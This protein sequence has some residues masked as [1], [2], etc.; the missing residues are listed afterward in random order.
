MDKPHSE[1]SFILGE[2]RVTNGSDMM[3]P[4]MSPGWSY[5][6]TPELQPGLSFSEMIF[7]LGKGY[8]LPMHISM[9]FFMKV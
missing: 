7:M 1:G 8:I 9:L 3:E 6:A 4:E 2:V 5:K